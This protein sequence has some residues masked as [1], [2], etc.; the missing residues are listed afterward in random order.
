[1]TDVKFVKTDLYMMMELLLL[2]VDLTK[3]M[4]L[5]STLTL[6]LITPGHMMY[7]LTK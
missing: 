6:V 5:S 1:M 2:D 4:D 7:P 3:E